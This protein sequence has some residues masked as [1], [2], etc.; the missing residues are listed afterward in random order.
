M[1]LATGDERSEK[2]TRDQVA[3]MRERARELRSFLPPMLVTIGRVCVPVPLLILA[4]PLPL[5]RPL[6]AS[7]AYYIILI[8]FFL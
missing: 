7:F 2:A 5:S 3:A 6:S 1:L 8:K 4:L